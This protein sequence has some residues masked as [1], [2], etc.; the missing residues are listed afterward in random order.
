MGYS[1]FDLKMSN[2][3]VLVSVRL[4]ARLN[5][6]AGTQTA[7]HFKSHH[8][9]FPTFHLQFSLEISLDLSDKNQPWTVDV[10]SRPIHCVSEKENC[11]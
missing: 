9:L 2:Q 6:Y 8:N 5:G 7:Y 11:L 4:L 1:E 10:T 3:S